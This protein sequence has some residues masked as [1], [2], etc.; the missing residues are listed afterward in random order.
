LAIPY[1]KD[2]G[3]HTTAITHSKDKEEMAT[4]LGADYV[5]K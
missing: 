4:K 3:F 1:S 5:V 2:A